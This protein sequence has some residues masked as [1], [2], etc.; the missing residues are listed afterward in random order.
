MNLLTTK[1]VRKDAPIQTMIVQNSMMLTLLDN[2]P[3][4]WD[5]VNA[6]DEMS[7]L[8]AHFLYMHA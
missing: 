1:A 3:I 4:R 6:G 5:V 2:V 7:F 8:I